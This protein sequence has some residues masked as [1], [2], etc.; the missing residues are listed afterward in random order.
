MRRGAFRSSERGGNVR[1]VPGCNLMYDRARRRP[2]ATPSAD[3]APRV[4][5]GVAAPA[6]HRFA[7]LAI[8]QLCKHDASCPHGDPCPTHAP[9]KMTST[10]P[11]GL[12]APKPVTLS[13]LLK[14]EPEIVVNR[15][16]SVTFD[17]SGAPTTSAFT[18]PPPHKELQAER[19]KQGSDVR[20]AFKALSDPERAKQL[21]LVKSTASDVEQIGIDAEILPDS[22]AE[23]AEKHL[24]PGFSGEDFRATVKGLDEHTQSQATAAFF[25]GLSTP[26]GDTPPPVRKQLSKLHKYGAQL[27]SSLRTPTEFVSAPIDVKGSLGGQQH[28]TSKTEPKIPGGSSSHAY[29]D[30]RRV[31]RQNEATKEAAK[32]GLGPGEQIVSSGLAATV[33][34]LS[35]M[36]SPWSA[37]NSEA[38]QLHDD[39]RIER[40]RVVRETAKAQANVLASALKLP[41]DT[42]EQEAD[43]PFVPRDRPTS[44]VRK[45]FKGSTDSE[46]EEEEET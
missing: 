25:G 16:S 46:S 3:A 34:T 8:V 23:K 33:G 29:S 13:P 5:S 19:R 32:S 15:S 42:T 27:Y 31:K 40:Q 17:T 10:P 36:M 30:R 11:T 38:P 21:A 9:K 45:K 20:S 22:H 28:P 37:Q 41:I 7:S 4:R 39:E 2:T 43:A 44:P 35:T 12:L 26:R 14:T 24:T 1:S 18:K 6:L